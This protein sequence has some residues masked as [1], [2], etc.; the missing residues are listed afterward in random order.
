MK[1][2]RAWACVGPRGLAGLLLVAAATVAGAQTHGTIVGAVTD[3][4]TGKPIAGALVTAASPS[5]QGEQAA[6]TD[7][8]GRFTITLLPP[9]RYRIS[10]HLQGYLPAERGDLVLR[11]D[12]TLRANLVLAPEA[13]Q[14]DE[15]LVKTGIAP[16]VNVGT[17]EEGAVI[18]RE[19]LATVP[20]TRDYE[21]T[22]IIIPTAQRDSGGIAF[23]GATSPENNYILDGFRV[24]DPGYNYLGANFPTNF[25]EQL[26]VKIGGFL[27]EYGYT[28]AGV[29]NAVL[30]SG[31]NEFHGSIWGNLTPGLLTPAEVYP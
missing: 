8:Q 13:V 17:A 20:T 29:V 28:S 5:L 27:P 18:S 26:D 2:S 7:A 16:A 14:A 6:V 12:Y 15:Q 19:F 22:M 21:G 24:G 11:V 23:A 25:V 3:A 30:K 10:G 4:S 1:Q 9:G 31:S